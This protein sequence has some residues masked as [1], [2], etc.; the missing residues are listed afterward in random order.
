[1]KKMIF[2]AALSIASSTSVFAHDTS[3]FESSDPVVYNY[4][5][6]LDIKRVISITDTSDDQG[7]V[8]ATLI[9]E[10]SQGR[11]KTVNFSQAGG[12]GREG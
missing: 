9:Y 3:N 5:M 1:M 11:V 8:P 6:A 2:V 10:D 7:V 4:G 12:L